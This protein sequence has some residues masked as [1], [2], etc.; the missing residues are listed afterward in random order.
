MAAHNTPGDVWIIVN[1]KVIDVSEFVKTHPGGEAAI[2]AFAG[3]DASVEWNMIH[4][5]DFLDIHVKDK[6]LGEIGGTSKIPIGNGSTTVASSGGGLTMEEVA[7][8]NKERLADAKSL[9]DEWRAVAIVLLFVPLCLLRRGT[10]GL[11]RPGIR[12][13]PSFS[14]LRLR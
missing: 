2:M 8:H 1:N 14:S 13:C 11:L 7:K 12:L 5:P 4:K 10:G 6:I 3:K 9:R